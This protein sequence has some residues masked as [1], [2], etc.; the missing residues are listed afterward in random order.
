MN[1][2]EYQAKSLLKSMASQ[3]KEEML[4]LLLT[5]RRNSKQSRRECM[6]GKSS[7]SC[8]WKKAGGVKFVKSSSEVSTVA[9]EL[10]GKKLITHQSGPDGQP[11]NSVLVASAADIK[12][13]I[14]WERL[15]TALQNKLPLWHPPQEA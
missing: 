6:A 7:S 11:I 12:R 1:L 5:G 2:H 14:A 4:P 8:G 15:L 10:L 3:F 13:G 9:K